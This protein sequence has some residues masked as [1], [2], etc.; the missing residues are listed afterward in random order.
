MC[1]CVCLCKLNSSINHRLR[2]PEIQLDSLVPLICIQRLKTKEHA[3][4]SGMRR[5]ASGKFFQ[6][7]LLKNAEI[8]WIVWDFSPSLFGHFFC[9]WWRWG[10]VPNGI[11][12]FRELNCQ[13]W[14]L[15]TT[16]LR[17]PCFPKSLFTPLGSFA[18]KLAANTRLVA[19]KNN[20]RNALPL[21]KEA[22]PWE[23]LSNQSVRKPCRSMAL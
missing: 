23:L 9:W 15:Q 8:C 17:S 19:E 6:L 3:K 4:L 22:E 5:S 11:S 1:S 20:R 7:G 12:T 10:K 14:R 2:Q 16:P 18:A 21:L 13:F